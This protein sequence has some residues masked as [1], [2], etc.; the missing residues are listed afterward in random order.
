MKMG[1]RENAA[2][3][4]EIEVCVP[5]GAKLRNLAGHPGP[6]AGIQRALDCGSEAAMT[7]ALGLT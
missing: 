2:R 3:A 7:K 1:F 5:N 6:R 4:T